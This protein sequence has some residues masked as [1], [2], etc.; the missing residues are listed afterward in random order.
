MKPETLRELLESQGPLG[1]EL[2]SKGGGLDYFTDLLDATVYRSC[3]ECGDEGWVVRLQGGGCDPASGDEGEPPDISQEPCPTCADSPTAIVESALR[4]RAISDMVSGLDNVLRDTK[5]GFNVESAEELAPHIVDAVLSVVLPRV[6]WA[7]E[8]LALAA[9]V[10][11]ETEE[12]G[13][14]VIVHAESEQ[15]LAVLEEEPH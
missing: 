11:L 13:F 9:D 5:A 10:A 2:A 4:E 14:L 3:S 6:R 1:K 8:V 12:D 7:K 15:R